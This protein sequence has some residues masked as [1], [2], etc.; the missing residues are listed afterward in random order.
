MC[1]LDAVAVD[2]E[3]RRLP[4][5]ASLTAREAVP[6]ADVAECRRRA[7]YLRIISRSRFNS[8][9]IHSLHSRP[10]RDFSLKHRLSIPTGCAIVR[11]RSYFSSRKGNPLQDGGR[12][13]SGLLALVELQQMGGVAGEVPCSRISSSLLTDYRGSASLQ[14]RVAA[15]A[16]FYQHTLKGLI[17][18][19]FKPC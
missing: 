1:G 17:M 2:D 12:K 9:A 7:M 5:V 11:N 16:D 4:Q 13:A 14:S 10:S 8:G 19:R 6:V 18:S 15:P 3:T